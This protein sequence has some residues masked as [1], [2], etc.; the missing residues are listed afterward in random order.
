MKKSLIMFVM[1]VGS[2]GLHASHYSSE[3]RNVDLDKLASQHA[4]YSNFKNSKAAQ[5]VFFA[6]QRGCD[7]DIVQTFVNYARSKS[8][9]SVVDCLFK[10]DVTQAYKTTSPYVLELEEKVNRSSLRAAQ[11][12]QA[13]DELTNLRATPVFFDNYNR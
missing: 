5:L 12:E 8:P 7:D 4:A 11:R 6:I 1:I 9:S 2:I 3:T 13:R 10:Y